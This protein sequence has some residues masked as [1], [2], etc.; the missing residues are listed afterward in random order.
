[1]LEEIL[2]PSMENGG[3]AQGGFEVVPSERQQSGRGTG[4]QQRVEA[5]LVVLNEPVQFVRQRK[6]DVEIGDGQQVLGL[7]LQP[8]STL[9]PLASGT[10]AIAAR[11]RHEGFLAAV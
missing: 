1:M 2:R 11:V 5:G 8:L 4:E 9:E 7:L 3:D 6:H 10:M